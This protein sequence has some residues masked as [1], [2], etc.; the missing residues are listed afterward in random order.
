V[1]EV[2]NKTRPTGYTTALKLMQIMHEK[3]II[4]RDESAR[5]HV[6]RTSSPEGQTQR[7]LV[8]DLLDRAFGGSAQQLVMRA[9]QAK[10][11]SPE[12]LAAIRHLIEEL[13]AKNREDSK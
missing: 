6:Y 8:R 13:E 3:G 10:K 9:L 12:E 4:S 11:T 2:L 1:H 7:T 5:A